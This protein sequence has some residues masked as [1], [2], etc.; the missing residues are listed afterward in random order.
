MQ[1]TV[2]RKLFAFRVQVVNRRGT[3]TTQNEAKRSIL[4]LLET[5][6]RGAAVIR[7]D[8]WG[9]KV[10]QRTDKELVSVQKALFIVAEGRIRERT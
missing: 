10:E 2:N 1:V 7:V 5:F 9:C 8:N 6:E 3:V 4:N